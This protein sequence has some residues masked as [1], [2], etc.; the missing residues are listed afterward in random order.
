MADFEK[1]LSLEDALTDN[2]PEV[3]EE[4]KRDFI[5]TLEAEPYDDVIGETCGKCDYIPLLDDDAE[6]SGNHEHQNKP[7]IDGNHVEPAAASQPAVL[8]NGDREIEENFMTESSRVSMGEEKMYSE[9]RTQ[10]EPWQLETEHCFEPQPVFQPVQQSVPLESNKDHDL[11]SELLLLPSSETKSRPAFTEHFGA[12]GDLP[13][14]FTKNEAFRDDWL[15]DGQVRAEEAEDLEYF[16]KQEGSPGEVLHEHSPWEATSFPVESAKDDH[17]GSHWQPTIREQQVLGMHHPSEPGHTAEFAL[18]EDSVATVTL[19]ELAGEVEVSDWQQTNTRVPLDSSETLDKNGNIPSAP[20]FDEA[21]VPETNVAGDK[22]FFPKHDLLKESRSESKEID[23]ATAL[24]AVEMADDDILLKHISKP[25]QELQEVSSEPTEIVEDKE[26]ESESLDAH[27]GAIQA[28]SDIS[29]GDY[30]P[31][32]NPSIVCVPDVLGF[33]VVTLPLEIVIPKDASLQ[34]KNL[35]EESIPEGSGFEAVAVPRRTEDKTLRHPD[36]NKESVLEFL[37]FE[38]TSVSQDESWPVENLNKE[39]VPE[40]LGLVAGNISLEM[41]IPEDKSLLQHNS[42]KESIADVL[43]VDEEAISL[44]VEESLS[45]HNSDKESAREVCGINADSVLVK[46]EQLS[47][48]NQEHHEEAM[49]IEK[50]KERKPEELTFGEE[51]VNEI[52]DEEAGVKTFD[53]HT[54]SLGMEYKSSAQQRS[55]I[56]EGLGLDAAT[57]SLGL[58]EESSQYQN[59]VSDRVFDVIVRNEPLPYQNLELLQQYKGPADDVEQKRT[60]PGVL[61]LDTTTLH[62]DNAVPKN[63]IQSQLESETHQERPTAEPLAPALTHGQQELLSEA[64]STNAFNIPSSMELQEASPYLGPQFDSL[65]APADVVTESDVNFF[66]E[67]RAPADGACTVEE[68]K[69]TAAPCPFLHS[70]PGTLLQSADGILDELKASVPEAQAPATVSVLEDH[71]SESSDQHTEEPVLETSASLKQVSIPSEQGYDQA[72]PVAVPVANIKDKHP[73]DLL[74]S[75]PIESPL[76]SEPRSNTRTASRTKA[77]HKKAAELM[78]TKSEAA[79]D[80][81]TPEGAPAMIKK[82]KKK[83]KQKKTLQARAAEVFPGNDAG[84]EFSYVTSSAAEMLKSDIQSDQPIENLEGRTSLRGYAVKEPTKVIRQTSPGADSV[85]VSDEKHN[86]NP[87]PQIIQTNE[88]LLAAPSSR[89]AEQFVK[90]EQMEDRL[91]SQTQGKL[92][93]LPINLLENRTE[94]TKIE[95]PKI[96]TTPKG[97]GLK[98]KN[99]KHSELKAI[100]PEG[101]SKEL[102]THLDCKT[103]VASFLDSNVQREDT[104]QFGNK[105][106]EEKKRTQPPYEEFQNVEVLLVK[107]PSRLE[108]QSNMAVF[109]VVLT[110]DNLTET[111]IGHESKKV[112]SSYPDF[113]TEYAKDN[114]RVQDCVGP[115]QSAKL[116]KSRNCDRKKKVGHSSLDSQDVFESKIAGGKGQASSVMPLNE[117]YKVSECADKSGLLQNISSDHL[118]TKKDQ[119]LLSCG[120]LVEIEENIHSAVSLNNK[121]DVGCFEA[122]H[123]KFGI[124]SSKPN[125]P[126]DIRTDLD[127]VEVFAGPT[128]SKEDTVQTKPSFEPTVPFQSVESE[129]IML[130]S[131][132]PDLCA[133]IKDVAVHKQALAEATPTLEN[134]I[135]MVNI[136]IYPFP[137]ST[138]MEVSSEYKVIAEGTITLQA[139]SESVVH[140]ESKANMMEAVLSK[141]PVLAEGKSAMTPGPVSSE[142]TLCVGIRKD[143]AL[144]SS[145]P[146]ATIESEGDLALV[147]TD[148]QI[149]G[150]SSVS[151]TEVTVKEPSLIGKKKSGRGSLKRSRNGDSK[152]AKTSIVA[153]GEEITKDNSVPHKSSEGMVTPSK[154]SL[155]LGA[156]ANVPVCTSTPLLQDTSS[157]VSLF[158]HESEEYTDILNLKED[159]TS[160]PSV[161]EVQ[162][163]CRAGVSDEIK[164]IPCTFIQLAASLDIEEDFSDISSTNNRAK[165]KSHVEKT[166]K[167]RPMASLPLKNVESTEPPGKDSMIALTKD[168][169]KGKRIKEDEKVKCLH[170]E[171]PVNFDSEADEPG[172]LSVFENKDKPFLSDKIKPY[173]TSFLE[174]SAYLECPAALE[175]HPNVAQLDE[176]VN[177]SLLEVGVIDTL[178]IKDIT[179]SPINID[180][181][182]KSSV[183]LDVSAALLPSSKSHS[184]LDVSLAE[185]PFLALR[186]KAGQHCVSLEVKDVKNTAFEAFLSCDG[187]TDSA[188]APR[189]SLPAEGTQE[190]PVVD[191]VSA[192]DCEQKTVTPED[193]A[194]KTEVSLKDEISMEDTHFKSRLEKPIKSGQAEAK[195]TIKT[196]LTVRG[197]E[198]MKGYMRPT[199]SQGLLSP[200]PRS[201]VHDAMN[202]NQTRDRSTSQRRPEKVNLEASSAAE[203][204]AGSI[205]AP[206]SKELPPSPEKKVKASAVAASAKPA[207][208]KGR[209]ASTTSPKQSTPPPGKKASSPA[210]VASSTP[211]RPAS[212]SARPSNL[213]PKDSTTPRS[214][215]LTPKEMKPKG[216]DLKSPIKS[217]EKKTPVSKAS[218]TVTPRAAVKPATGTPKAAMVPAVAVASTTGSAPKNT[219]STTPRRPTTIKA[220]AKPVEAKKATMTAKSADLS[221]PKT[222]PVNTGK[223]NATTPSSPGTNFGPAAP[224]NRPKPSKSVMTKPI[225]ESNATT[226]GKKVPVARAPTSKVNVA[227]KA[228]RPGSVPAPDLKNVR[229]KIGSTDNLKYQPGGGKAKVE[230][231]PESAGAIRKPSAPLP[232]TRTATTK[233]TVSKETAQ[234]DSNGRVQIVSKKVNYSHV[235]S[236]CGSKDNI[237]HVPGGGNVQILNKKVDPSKVTAKCGSKVNIKHKPGGGDV[238]IENH[239]SS[240]K[241]KVQ[242]KV[243]SLDNMGHAPAGGKVK[244][245]GSENAGD[246]VQTPQNEDLSTPQGLAGSEMQQNDVPAEGSDQR[247]TQNFDNQIQ[248]T[249]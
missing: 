22:E 231:R 134:K 190:S 116:K 145:E 248:E 154:H 125:V 4:I 149:G 246:M 114:S 237:K 26:I 74:Q 41:K 165:N 21:G 6:K 153:Q 47:K 80:E 84:T 142:H 202:T 238:K 43:G 123:R 217:A 222:A 122:K 130:L 140:D 57:P 119:N 75:K 1:D 108:N 82:K 18:L 221:R 45:Q 35:N 36:S 173:E 9:F 210:P 98:N 70:E 235:Q 136:N 131:S 167:G 212:S 100:F 205:S 34:Q 63:K 2:P 195:K 214:S 188:E 234:K 23:Q 197:P 139:S 28:A 60:I 46:T 40:V 211:K 236:K 39:C 66:T 101:K 112:K 180:T 118:Q 110:K 249:N 242:S 227:P 247:E 117:N 89:E 148:L 150:A 115:Q 13:A 20:T 230:K 183:S 141:L 176:Q 213:T 177:I 53:T 187:N 160:L 8:E 175:M 17:T 143:A 155:S 10:K 240:V 71:K 58:K 94:M 67:A 91:L 133:E 228:A 147:S 107:Q 79:Q 168:K 164:E 158:D 64:P 29:E 135:D 169:T 241:D 203:A 216:L 206:P 24:V 30:L 111:S 127:E 224:I 219:S 44:R 243:E 225:P 239:Q 106:L 31:E 244:S 76:A 184:I 3:E 102:G 208:A 185:P 55:C 83:P 218:T 59:D 128:E 27:A 73:A 193:A 126:V 16:A 157:A 19:A 220:D 96:Q 159:A 191:K 72:K 121:T 245:E 86:R 109:P 52:A 42:N 137:D 138:S 49:E 152:G 97:A 14:A 200:Q 194:S 163:V 54:V 209:P 144:V 170:S 25:Q 223:S 90:G 229:S 172:D 129:S 15:G 233:T 132:E 156:K 120:E 146:V 103:D 161:L 51:A 69:R 166:Q 196:D 198:S 33:E 48:F 93:L 181:K 88:V 179:A 215:T 50:H 65:V 105:T 199:K 124:L 11:L 207:T 85:G 201:S 12:S 174:R 92:S 178:E 104:A 192:G 32:Q 56:V 162:N 81:W 37:G 232:V 182:T 61:P 99:K 78:D 5:S 204:I 87:V 77:L 186:D 226:D 171:T 95:D 38:E 62:V 68:E 151:S 113:N 7:K 189:I